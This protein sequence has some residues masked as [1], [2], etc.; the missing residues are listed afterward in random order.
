MK[1]LVER[2]G[3]LYSTF[4]EDALLQC[5]KG[6]KAAGMRARKISLEIERLMKMFRKTSLDLSKE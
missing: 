4:N 3:E 2:I 5:E 1:E 6:N